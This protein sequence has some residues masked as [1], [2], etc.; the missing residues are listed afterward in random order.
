M[1]VMCSFAACKAQTGLCG[2][3]KVMFGVA[4]LAAIGL[5]V[6]FVLG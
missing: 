5:S 6:Y 3:E 4:L 1:S 2:H